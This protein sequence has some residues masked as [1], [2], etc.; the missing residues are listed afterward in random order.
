MLKD[1]YNDIFG[2][3]KRIMVVMAHSDDLEVFSG[4]TVARLIADGKRVRSVKLTTGN[5]GSKERD[6]SA[7]ELTK[8]R[9]EEDEKAM[10]ILGIPRE[11]SIYFEFDD[12]SIDNS[13]EVI[14]AI[15]LQI[16]QFKPE[17]VMTTNPE[18]VIVTHLSGD[19]WVNHRDHRNTALSTLDAAYPYSR[20][21]LFFPEH[22]KET[23]AA[24]HACTEFLL[25]DYY[26]HPQTV[27]INVDDY[28]ETRIKA[29]EC[30]KSQV[31]DGEAQE[32]TDFF[33]KHA[34]VES[35]FELFR[36]V[37]AD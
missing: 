11:D 31:A 27:A 10:K 33:T 36:Y 17:L 1:L 14:G 37:V 29:M 6:V 28:I 26:T 25:A 3:K 24:S 21:K 16:R 32:S 4:G 34:G 23:D 18:D 13:H 35:R 22:F 19:N 30:H 7:E 8:T 2:D 5:K 20:D 9:R 12:G 15:A